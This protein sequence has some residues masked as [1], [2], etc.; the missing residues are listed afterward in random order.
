MCVCVCVQR[1]SE[2]SS[3]VVISVLWF[4]S[5]W[6]ICQRTSLIISLFSDL[7]WLLTVSTCMSAHL[8]VCLFTCLSF[9]LSTFLSVCLPIC[10]SGYL[11]V[12]LPVCLPVEVSDRCSVFTSWCL[13]SLWSSLTHTNKP[14]LCLQNICCRGN[15]N[16]LDSTVTKISCELT[17]PEVAAVRWAELHD[18]IMFVE[19]LIRCEFHYCVIIYAFIVCQQVYRTH[20]HL[21]V[22]NL[23]TTEKVK[24]Q[25]W[26]L[27]VWTETDPGSESLWYK[28][29]RGNDPLCYFCNRFNPHKQKFM[30]LI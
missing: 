6:I 3:L 4:P 30:F 21:S 29:V 12:Y 22:E 8:S 19:N 10:L 13:N 23:N 1:C 11:L 26:A 9:C 7:C 27:R 2:V 25:L 28:E 5:E 24:H 17:G 16:L 15:S 14:C 20:L 18:G